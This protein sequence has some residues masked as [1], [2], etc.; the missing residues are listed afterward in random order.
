MRLSK[1]TR[2][3]AGSALALPV[4]IAS[5]ADPGAGARDFSI[6]PQKL[7]DAL[8]EFALQADISIGG[9]G[10]CSGAAPGLQGH[11]SLDEGLRRLLAGA[12]CRF[13]FADPRTVRLLPAPPS[14]KAAQA[15]AEAPPEEIMVS[16]T[17]RLAAVDRLPDAVSV[18]SAEQLDTTHDVDIADTIGRIAGMSMTNLGPGRDKIMLRG[19]SDG[20]F[21]GR[22]QSTVGTYLDTLPVNYN[23]PDPDLKLSDVEAIEVIRGPQGALYGGGSLSGVY[24]VVTHKPDLDSYG[25]AVTLDYGWTEGASSSRSI[26][27]M[28][29]L[30][31]AQGVSALRIVAYGDLDGGYLNDGDLRQSDVDRTARDGGRAAWET[32]L[33]DDWT[34]TA[35][36]A[37][38]AL[39]TADAQYTTGPRPRNR[40]NRVAEADT[41]DF[42][43]G[44]FTLSGQ[45]DWGRLDSSTGYVHHTTS[46]R[47]DASAALSLF[48]DTDAKDIGIYDEVVS[49][50]LLIEDLVAG[51]A[52][53]GPL[54]WL[55]G[56][57]AAATDEQSSDALR[58]RA[59]RSS[60]VLRYQELRGDRL[61]EGAPYGEVTYD[62][63]SGW[64]AGFGLRLFDT[65]LTTTSVV[66]LPGRARTLDRQAGY[67]GWAPKVSLQ[68]EI[69]P[70]DMAYLLYSEGYRAGGFNSGGVTA[71]TAAQRL[72]RPDRL[73]N[74]EAGIK[75]RLADGLVEVRSAV[76]C[77]FWDTIQTDQ[78]LPTGL[79]Y[80]T[81]VGD[82]R[83]L[84][85]ETE[86]ALHPLTGLSLGLDSLLNSARLTHVAPVFS[87]PITSALPGVA[88]AT[89]GLTVDDQTALDDAFTLLL[90]GKLAY[91]GRSRLTFQTALSQTMG[92]YVT[93]RL[94]AGVA[95]GSWR[96]L[97]V[98]DNPANSQGDTF[99]FGNPFSFGQVRQV[100]P[101]RPRTL[102]LVLSANF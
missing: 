5:A 101:L 83:I 102:S 64:Q 89:I 49:T 45:L 75:S 85:W 58:S 12:P 76:F 26:D 69:T 35:A 71:P 57:Y 74:V 96:L 23:A 50:D 79:A 3:C 78:Y 41:N 25:A 19:L 95:S 90:G 33:G 54:Q 34:V 14:V 53:D 39:D 17:K 73:R 99:A 94:S 44:S 37:V 100:T 21:T 32:R 63:G 61:R 77:D 88:D 10:V 2:L 62:F 6:H 16:A 86:A 81:N 42:A 48:D 93:S 70:Q 84:G 80:T 8:L 66:T 87:N 68:Y 7:S 30:P 40:A 82:A 59:G 1:V 24:R 31:L 9:V 36:G 22:T 98:L 4:A 38:Q 15:P 46:N 29:N 72:F 52:S 65:E 55:A 56:L 91:V 27:G 11:F 20:S 51:S 92:G 18:V 60:P 28:V 47:Y 97:A 67:R 43:Q 13:E